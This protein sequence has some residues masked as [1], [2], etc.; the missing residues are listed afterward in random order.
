MVFHHAIDD[1]VGDAA[2]FDG[3]VGDCKGTTA[4]GGN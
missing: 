1:P 3:V 4:I 2:A